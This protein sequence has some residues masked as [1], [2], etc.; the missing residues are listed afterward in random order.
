M[1][2]F[3]LV[4]IDI[5]ELWIINYEYFCSWILISLFKGSF[6]RCYYLD[7][8]SNILSLIKY[9]KYNHVSLNTIYFIVIQT[10][11]AYF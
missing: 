9:L 3:N 5:L 8:I 10:N 7:K 6:K 1:E 2:R 4:L 11:N